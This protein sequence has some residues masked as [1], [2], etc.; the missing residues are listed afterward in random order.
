MWKYETSSIIPYPNILYVHMGLP[1]IPG[2]QALHHLYPALFVLRIVTLKM[3]LLKNQ[4]VFVISTLFCNEGCERHF[5]LWKGCQ[6]QKRLGTYVLEQ[7]YWRQQPR[8]MKTCLNITWKHLVSWFMH[9]NVALCVIV[10]TL[11]YCWG[12]KRMHYLFTG[13]ITLF[14][15]DH[16][17]WTRNPS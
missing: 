5:I 13:L 3:K 12:N 17:F 1:T 16:N 11:W 15:L 8:W 7:D 4:T 10:T 6:P 2:P 9:Y 14:I